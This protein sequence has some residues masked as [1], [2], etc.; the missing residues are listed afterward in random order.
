MFEFDSCRMRQT[1]RIGEDKLGSCVE[2]RGERARTRCVG[3]VF[4]FRWRRWNERGGCESIIFIDNK[5]KKENS[6][7]GY[8]WK[9]S[10]V[11]SFDDLDHWFVDVLFPFSSPLSLPLCFFI[12][13][14]LS[15]WRRRK[16]PVCCIDVEE[17][18][19]PVFTPL[20][21]F[22]SFPVPICHLVLL[23]GANICSVDMDDVSTLQVR[24]SF[25]L[26]YHDRTIAAVHGRKA[27]RYE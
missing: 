23:V 14:F 18:F 8:A 19:N 1:R 12:S 22:A 6:Y 17:R 24:F 3:R 26:S 10:R 9:W 13:F 25:F 4:G 7:V 11:R 27:K 21:L 15:C 16:E 2:W 20:L 5:D